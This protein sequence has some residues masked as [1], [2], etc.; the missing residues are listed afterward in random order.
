MNTRE[1]VHLLN[2]KA[3]G[4]GGSV[5]ENI[6]PLD[7]HAPPGLAMT[8][9]KARLAMTKIAVIARSNATRQSRSSI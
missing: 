6:K 7:R 4:H 1:T 8:S 2:E 3:F 5:P 9:G